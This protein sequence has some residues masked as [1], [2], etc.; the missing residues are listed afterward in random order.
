LV[1]LMVSF[2][3]L[4]FLIFDA[5]TIDYLLILACGILH[6]WDLEMSTETC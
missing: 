3:F 6:P 1:H 5:W 2:L 4:F